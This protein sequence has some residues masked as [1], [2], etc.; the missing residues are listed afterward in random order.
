[1]SASAV[2][3]S[4]IQGFG[5]M[6]TTGIEAHT[7][8]QVTTINAPNLQGSDG[9]MIIDSGDTSRSDNGKLKVRGGV[10]GGTKTNV[11][12]AGVWNSG[13][14]LGPLGAVS[15]AT[16]GE[17]LSAGTLL[18]GLKIPPLGEHSMD[19][20]VVYTLSNV[21]LDGHVAWRAV[22]DP[23][24]SDNLSVG[25]MN[26]GEALTVDGWMGMAVTGGP[27]TFS[28]EVSVSGHVII[29]QS[30]SIRG[31]EGVIVD[32]RCS[33]NGEV[34]IGSSLNV[35]QTLLASGNVLLQSQLSVTGE[36]ILSNTL[37][38]KGP[39]ST[40]H[41][42]VRAGSLS[43][44]GDVLTSGHLSV[45][46]NLTVNGTT[47]TI[48]STTLAIEDK[49]IEVGVVSNPTDDTAVGAG[50]VVK[51]ATDKEIVYTRST[52]GSQSTQQLSAFQLSE[53]VVLGKKTKP[54]DGTITSS[55]STSQR[56]QAVHLGDMSSTDGH[57][58]IVA[59]ISNGKLQFWY[60]QDI[61]DDSDMDLVPSTSATL[62]FEIQKP[63]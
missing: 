31:P 17:H 26:I 27:A 5:T 30:L 59:D 24:S 42:A 9:D 25:Y 13:L 20:D 50:L 52:P 55:L 57:W 43:V 29:G 63:T 45:N 4:N 2:P 19:V 7:I 8:R 14:A 37:E 3:L 54:F 21:G 23:S 22:S 32:G 36:T 12:E 34:V 28:R 62:A 39:S 1:M 38:V 18:T 56:S 40:F 35:G 46:G 11:V 10:S 6:K 58:M 49:T 61:P 53:D 41:G 16:V 33:V 47:T 15:V 60:G 44:H 51:G 48:N